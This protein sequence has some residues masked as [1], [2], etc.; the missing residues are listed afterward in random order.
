MDPAT[1]AP[2][3]NPIPSEA[4]ETSTMTPQEAGAP[5][6]PS[7]PL[8]PPWDRIFSLGTRVFVWVLLAGILYLLRPF[9]LLVFLT[10]VFAY[11]LEHG[12]QGLQHR[13]QNRVVR[14]VLVSVVF[15]GTLITL[16][17]ALA[18]AFRQQAA[19]LAKE[20][21]VYLEKIDAE[22]EAARNKYAWARSQIPADLKAIDLVEY[23][24]NWVPKESPGEETEPRQPLTP[25]DAE[26]IGPPE[27]ASTPSAT[28]I[29]RRTEESR[30]S[31]TGAMDL[32]HNIAS[33]IFGISS[34]FLLSLLFS[35]LIVLD[36]AHLKKAVQGLA[37]TKLGFIYDEVADNI[38]DFGVTL[39]RA[40]EA[41]L[42]IAMVNT[43]LTALGLWLLGMS[44]N[45]V[46]L[47][48]VVFFCSFIPVA[49]VFISSTPICLQA[50][51]QEGM[52]L[53]LAA[54]AMVLVVHFIEA[55]FLN[56]KIYGHHLR[57][58]AV[59][60][61][62]V[63]TVAGKLVGVWGLVLGLPVVNYFFSHA[64]RYRKA[65]LLEASPATAPPA[66]PG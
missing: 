13:I 58:N 44:S 20:Y 4:N 34:A 11:I 57:M 1:L 15:V 49:G 19:T 27:A 66:Q 52:P 56:P 53:L 62:I 23:L 14:V 17:I 50:L 12:V 61:L 42:F 3:L 48:T 33:P 25:P 30:T 18:P 65:A 26:F 46:F 24:L 59:L 38:R 36:L 21:P 51:S 22:I 9:F 54:V 28:Q 37:K 41:Q 10:F 16:G 29:R 7:T 2:T 63:L 55:Y 45:L 60:V 31:L 8:P 35:F 64:I 40:L 39:G 5:A 6:T 32:L 47:S 43:I